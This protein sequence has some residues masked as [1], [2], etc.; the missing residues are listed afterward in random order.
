[1]TEGKF[2]YLRGNIGEYCQEQSY[3]YILRDS[4]LFVHIYLYDMAFMS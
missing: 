1:M 4:L 3:Q 2:I